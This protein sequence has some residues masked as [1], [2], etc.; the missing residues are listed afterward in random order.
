MD[1]THLLVQ[2]IIAIVCAGLANLLVP[3]RIPGKL[4]GL[5]LIGLAGVWVGRWSADYLSQQFGL[6]WAFLEWQLQ[7]VE[8]VPAIIG[9]AIVLYVVTAFLSWGRYGGRG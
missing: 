2:V 1:I 4:V 3:R 5:V 9:C 7:G 8:I 6:N